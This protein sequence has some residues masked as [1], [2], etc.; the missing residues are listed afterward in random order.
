MNERPANGVGVAPQLTSEECVRRRP[1]IEHSAASVEADDERWH[2]AAAYR[3]GKDLEG[4]VALG[5]RGDDTRDD[6]ISPIARL[7]ATF[8][9]LVAGYLSAALAFEDGELAGPNQILPL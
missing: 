5:S 9:V 7:A 6:L 1:W 4:L 3:E 8:G 2:L